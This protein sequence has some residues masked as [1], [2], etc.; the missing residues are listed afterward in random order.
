MRLLYYPVLFIAGVALLTGCSGSGEK[1]LGSKEN[2][3]KIFFT[4]S[5]ES[6]TITENSKDMIQFLEK[7]TGLY[8]KSSV[9]TNYITVVESFGSD[10]A[11]VAIMN[12]F[13]YLLANEKYQANA[14]L[15]ILRN[16]DSYYK[17]QIIASVA[18]GINKLEDIQGKRMA[19]TDPSSTSGYLLP[20]KML[21]DKNIVPVNTVFGMKHDNVVTMIY[22]GQVDA[23]ATYY[24]PPGPDGAIKD[25]RSRVL[26]QFPDVVEKI[27]IIEL[28]DSIPN[29]PIVFRKGIDIETKK[30]VKEALLKYVQTENGK[31]V[32]KIIYG[33]DGII[34]TKD[35]DYNDL[36]K[37]VKEM[38][39]DISTT[40]K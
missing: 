39:V 18:S 21:K 4:P 11:D 24:S 13:G 36:R 29:D 17:G 26:T 2:P 8:F 22:Q 30:K 3:V 23:G 14:E 7:E 34:E 37:M 32:F 27:K 31:K 6:E 12:S 20:S 16:Q 25:A 15:R 40:L 5:V 9:P 38:N 35:E 10:R 19:Y 33:I 28:T 1:T